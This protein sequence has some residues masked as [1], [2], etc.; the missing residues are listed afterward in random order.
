M[1]KVQLQI[2]L[3][4][5]SKRTI[6]LSI[7]PWA[8]DITLEAG[9]TAQIACLDIDTNEPV[10]LVV[11]EDGISLDAGLDIKVSRGDQEFRFVDE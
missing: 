9:V 6:S 5:A 1:P 7:E 11:T 4:N 10:A 8:R 3:N 2:S